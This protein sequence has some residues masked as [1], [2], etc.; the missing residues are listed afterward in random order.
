[1]SSFEKTYQTDPLRE[2]DHQREKHLCIEVSDE[3]FRAKLDIHFSPGPPAYIKENFEIARLTSEEKRVKINEKSKSK[4]VKK[5]SPKISTKSNKSAV[6][7]LQEK[8]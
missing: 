8:L 5:K 6:E 1:M 7:S 4:K 2:K 3:D